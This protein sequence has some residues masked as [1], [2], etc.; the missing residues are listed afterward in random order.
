MPLNLDISKAHMDSKRGQSQQNGHMEGFCSCANCSLI[1]QHA[2]STL[3]W[4]WWSN[5]QSQSKR[6]FNSFNR[7]LV[8]SYYLKIFGVGNDWFALLIKYVTT[9]SYAPFH[10]TISLQNGPLY[11][12]PGISLYSFLW[13]E[14]CMSCL[15]VFFNFWT[16]TYYLLRQIRTKDKWL[17]RSFNN[18]V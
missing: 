7:G 15:I 17:C 14:K 1:P 9:V 4:F 2:I 6:N 12:R 10:V 11:I 16:L 5:P 8:V 18:Y 13:S 3:E